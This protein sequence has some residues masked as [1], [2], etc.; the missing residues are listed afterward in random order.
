[1][2]DRVHAVR[3]AALHADL[4]RAA[5]TGAASRG[6]ERAEDAARDR[7]GLM[8]SFTASPA[9]TVMQAPAPDAGRL[10][11]PLGYRRQAA[12]AQSAERFTRNE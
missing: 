4:A 6:D 10:L 5:R 9:P 11:E 8:A 12:L 3:G 1:M 2:L 7:R